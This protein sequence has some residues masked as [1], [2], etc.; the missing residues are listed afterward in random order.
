[1]VWLLQLVPRGGFKINLQRQR[2]SW[3]LLAA[4][5]T[6][7]LSLPPLRLVH[8]VLAELPAQRQFR[9]RLKGHLP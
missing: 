4:P 1:L 2:Q 3:L 6:A 8:L 5:Q 7:L 9:E